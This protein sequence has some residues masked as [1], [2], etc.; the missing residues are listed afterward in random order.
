MLLFH[1][2]KQGDRRIIHFLGLKIKYKKNRALDRALIESIVDEKVQNHLNTFLNCFCEP[3]DIK[4]KSGKLKLLNDGNTE[5]IRIVHEICKK[6]N[7][8]YWLSYGSLLGAIRHNAPIPWDYDADI[9]MPRE[10]Y[11][12]FFDVIEKEL[13]DTE[14][15]VYGASE[16]L[17]FRENV[18]ILTNKTGEEYLNLDIVPM[19][20]IHVDKSK[21]E[22]TI[23]NIIKEAENYYK[24]VF[25][26][27][28][29]IT[30]QGEIK[31]YNKKI[32]SFIEKLKANNLEENNFVA[33][34]I[35]H[36]RDNDEY[37]DFNDIFPLREVQYGEYKFFVPNNFEV[38]LKQSYGNSYLEFPPPS[39]FNMND[40][41]IWIDKFE[42]DV[43]KEILSNLRKIKID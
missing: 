29:H 28:K 2:E 18:I 12:K 9:A 22:N 37:C 30:S 17:P 32:N 14:V 5:L 16:I 13:K 27:E 11:N 31:E 1:K 43:A 34:L 23:L 4:P 6:Y 3:K 35:P 21:K 33:R 38:V 24:A 7:L 42:V 10:D 19:D 25:P 40:V 36:N 41:K 26:R 15:K 8:K 39:A 20:I